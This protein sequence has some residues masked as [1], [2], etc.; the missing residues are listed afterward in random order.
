MENKELELRKIAT[1]LANFKYSDELATYD[2][3]KINK[4]LIKTNSEI[5]LSA[6]GLACTIVN[7]A[8]SVVKA[9]KRYADASSLLRLVKTEAV[10][11][12]SQNDDLFIKQTRYEKLLKTMEELFNVLTNKVVVCTEDL[13]E[14]IKLLKEEI[15][16][17]DIYSVLVVVA[18]LVI[19][20]AT[21]LSKAEI[22]KRENS[23]VK[24][25]YDLNDAQEAKRKFYF[26]FIEKEAKIHNKERGIVTETYLKNIENLLLK[27]RVSFDEIKD[28]LKTDSELYEYFIWKYMRKLIEQLDNIISERIANS[29]IEELDKLTEVVCNSLTHLYDVEIEDYLKKP[30]CGLEGDEKWKQ[31]AI[32]NTVERVHQAME[33]FVHNAEMIHSR[34]GRL[35]CLLMW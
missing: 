26:E 3:D 17:D 1:A 13:E 20:N 22:S 19:R 32:N 24:P 34:G 10:T 27:K 7:M 31:I 29:I 8:N 11:Y 5:D 6:V 12:V 35:D 9:S 23:D 2:I 16:K 4:F 30:A 18:A 14:Y 15:F 25:H 21:I 33:A 28:M